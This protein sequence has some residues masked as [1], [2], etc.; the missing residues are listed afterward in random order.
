MLLPIPVSPLREK[1]S[2]NSQAELGNLVQE[3]VQLD[4]FCTAQ[5]TAYKSTP[6]GHQRYAGIQVTVVWFQVTQ[7]SPYSQCMSRDR[8]WP[9]GSIYS[10][11]QKKDAAWLSVWHRWMLQVGYW[12]WQAEHN[13]E[14]T[15]KTNKASDKN[16]SSIKW[17]CWLS[18]AFQ[19]HVSFGTTTVIAFWG[20]H[21]LQG[22]YFHRIFTGMILN[23]FAKND[24][25][26]TIL[27]LLKR[28]ETFPKASTLLLQF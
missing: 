11:V 16:S 15:E 17:S 12:P 21:A 20:C 14:C 8:S 5:A 27:R 4:C 7:P 25:L 19:F 26:G 6:T 3:Q 13:R 2:I 23:N 18:H 9:K 10:W 24:K 22:N 1:L 28:K